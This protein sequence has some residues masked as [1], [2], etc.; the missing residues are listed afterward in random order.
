MVLQCG[1]PRELSPLTCRVFSVSVSSELLDIR[2]EG[3]A[4]VLWR[5]GASKE[6]CG[7]GAGLGQERAGSG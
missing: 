2:P 5:V 1:E 3:L 6:A 4:C 7:E